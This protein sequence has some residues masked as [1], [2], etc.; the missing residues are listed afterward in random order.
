MYPGSNML[1]LSMGENVASISRKFSDTWVLHV[2]T[3]IPGELSGELFIKGWQCIY[4]IN[5][6]MCESR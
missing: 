3:S 6:F 5:M 4:K 1:W 2:N